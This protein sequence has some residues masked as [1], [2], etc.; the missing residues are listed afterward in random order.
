M[1]PLTNRERFVRTMAFRTVDR[2]PF[3]EWA[4]FWDK[5]VARWLGEGLPPQP[6]NGAYHRHFG[7][8]TI[9]GFG[10]GPQHW[11]L[12]VASKPH[13]GPVFDRDDYLAL[14]ARGALCNKG[15]FDLSP[16]D[17]IQPLHDAGEAPLAVTLKGAF[18][19]PRILLG[20]EHQFYAFT[21]QPELLHEMLDDA[22]AFLVWAQER[23]YA[24]IVPDYMMIMEDMSYNH[25]PMLSEA[26]FD[27]FMLPFYL[28][29]LA[30]ARARGVK[31]L[32]D[33]DGDMMDCAAWFRRAG[34]DG[35]LPLERQA[36]V[37]VAELRRRDPGAVLLG[38]FDKM[39]LPRGEEAIRAEFARLMPVARQGGFIPS[40]DHQTPPGVP[41]ANYRLYLKLLREFVE[42]AAR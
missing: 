39:V 34:A 17:R 32:V 26:M 21:D 27:E 7:L 28:R 5:T 11:P 13:G 19:Y 14:K 16:L 25:G 20:I 30:P 22:A 1:A 18:E 3:F 24:R 2:L 15:L 33:T 10:L 31:V 40:V 9:M 23:L 42:E 6:D 12:F 38:A 35:F 8:D 41:L 29:V 4:G 36:G 37:D